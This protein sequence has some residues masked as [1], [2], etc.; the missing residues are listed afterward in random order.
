MSEHANGIDTPRREL[1]GPAAM[2]LRGVTLT[3]LALYEA[4]LL[5]RLSLAVCLPCVGVGLPLLPGALNA[6][7]RQA[8]TQRAL[9]GRWSG[10]SV[11]S[12]YAAGPAGDPGPVWKR[13]TGCSETPPPGGTCS[14]S[15]STRWSDRC[16]RCFPRRPSPAG[17]GA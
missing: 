10:V 2:V 3:G 13:A 12:S 15:W 16:R 7:R 5:L 9:A 11:E 8:R 17:S 6:V 14:G 4:L 1:G